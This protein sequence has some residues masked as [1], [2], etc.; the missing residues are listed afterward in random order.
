M[1]ASTIYDVARR[2]GVSISTVSLALNSPARVRPE[3]LQRVLAAADELSFVPKADAVTR[4]RKGI[5]RIGVLAPFSSYPTFARRLNGVFRAVKG[6]GS[7]VVVYDQESAASSVLASLPLTRRLDGLIVMSLP[8]SDDVAQRLEAQRIATVLVEVERPGFSSVTIDD[9]AGGAMVAQHL[10]DR[11][12]RA[13]AFIGEEQSSHHY[14]SQSEARLAGFRAA[15][16]ANGGELHD[17]AIRLVSHGLEAAR[18][19]AHE[20]LATESPPSAVFAHDDVL[21]G[22]VL[23]AARELALDVPGDVAV[24]GFDDSDLADQ[25]GLTSVRQP[26]ED[27]GEVAAETLLAQL[28]NPDKAVQ[29][30]ALKLTIVERET[31]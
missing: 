27:S 4:A 19:A 5:G 8:F 12:H 13:F 21:A 20:I 3:T 14:R 11:G 29:H 31:T 23:K 6:T 9:A 24:V 25:L 18:S 10:I 17:A 15:I 1:T 28:A 7:E 16:E 30:V 2:A 22:G 26:L